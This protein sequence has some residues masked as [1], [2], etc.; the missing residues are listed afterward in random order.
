MAN[1]YDYCEDDGYAQPSARNVLRSAPLQPVGQTP[2][3]VIRPPPGG[4][5]PLN[6]VADPSARQAEVLYLQLLAQSLD[7]I[8]EV[9]TPVGGDTITDTYKSIFHNNTNSPVRVQVFADLTTPGCG[10]DLSLTPN[11]GNS[12]KY[13]VLSLTAN[14]RTEAVGIIL[15]PTMRIYAKNFQPLIP[16]VAV[17]VLRVRIFDPMKLLS[18]ANLYP[19]SRKQF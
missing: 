12:D 5:V 16:M 15:M 6:P 2:P 11:G 8:T 13:D 10:A 9:S 14:G 3:V 17:D 1:E 18:Y 7:I 19:Q 4:L